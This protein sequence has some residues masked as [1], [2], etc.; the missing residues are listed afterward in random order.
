MQMLTGPSEWLAI[1][2][3]VAKQVTLKRFQHRLGD[4]KGYHAVSF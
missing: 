1:D 2:L 3:P 4:R